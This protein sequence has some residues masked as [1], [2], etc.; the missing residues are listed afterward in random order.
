MKNNWP[1]KKLG[2]VISLLGGYA[3][4]SADYSDSG[5]QLIRISNVQN[6]YI[7]ES[8]KIYIS[9][10]LSE[11]IN[12]YILKEGDIL[13]SLTGNVGR[14]AKIKKSILPAV[15]NQR[16]AKIIFNGVL[17]EDF[18]YYL[19]VGCREFEN[20]CLNEAAGIAQKNISN[21]QVLEYKIPIPPLKIQQKIVERLDAIRKAQELNDLQ[22]SKTQELFESTILKDV[23]NIIFEEVSL[24]KVVLKQKFTNPKKLP[25]KEFHYVDISSIDRQSRQILLFKR[26]LGKNAPSR[27]RKEIRDGDTVWSTVRPYLKNIAHVISLPDPKVASTGFCILSPKTDVLDHNWLYYNVSSDWFINKVLPFQKGAA[28]PAVSDQ[29]ILSQTIKL[30]PIKDQQKIVEKLN[31]VQNYKKSLLKQKELLKELFDSVLNKSMKG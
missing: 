8:N 30:P 16:V 31:A 3:F 10:S 5:Y 1:I 21:R 6:G 18:L 14:V 4:K 17:S 22:I 23:L 2:E 25:E 19:L 7:G 27:A 24:G 29:D 13:I 11:K 28:Y 20:Y 15:L 26:I 9:N 12:Q